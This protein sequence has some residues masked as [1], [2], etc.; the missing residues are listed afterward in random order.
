MNKIIKLFIFCLFFCCFL[1]AKKYDLHYGIVQSV[2]DGDTLKVKTYKNNKIIKVRLFAIDCPEIR[3]DLGY[4]AKKFTESLVLNKNIR[5][6]EM[7]K[8]YKRIVGVVNFDGNNDLAIEILNNGLAWFEIEY[9]KTKRDIANVGDKYLLSFNRA[10]ENKI[11]IF[12]KTN[13]IRP[14]EFRRNKKK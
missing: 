14:R 3:Q 1:C 13:Q 6:V 9:I 7:G 8:S 2:I 11:G 5:I 12:V 4:E 10:R